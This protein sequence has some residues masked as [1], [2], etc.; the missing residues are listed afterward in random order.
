MEPL[1]R[2]YS[3]NF[4]SHHN[5]FDS[6]V[7]KIYFVTTGRNAWNSTW[8]QKYREDCMHPDFESAAE[9]AESLRKR[10]TVIYI[11]E[12]P[13]LG[14]SYEDSDLV[15]TE[16]N[17]Q[18][19]L[20]D[21]DTNRYTELY[22]ISLCKY[23]CGSDT[24]PMMENAYNFFKSTSGFWKHTPKLHNLI[25]LEPDDF[26]VMVERVSAKNEK[27]LH[28]TSK[29]VGSEFELEWAWEEVD[30]DDSFII[31]SSNEINNAIYSS[32]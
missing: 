13:C 21:F 29:S 4:K 3:S 16:I 6:F 31:N 1:G 25:I 22:G 7:G 32:S 18:E 28:Y 14:F 23:L 24:T 30:I 8:S 20:M 11:D 19:P 9:Y 5:L 2:I 26:D 10:G 17:T 15:V 27:Y 12:I